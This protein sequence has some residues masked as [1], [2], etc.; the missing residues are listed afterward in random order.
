MAGSQ[1]APAAARGRLL[2]AP[3]L[4]LLAALLPTSGFGF[5][6]LPSRVV[7]FALVNR[8]HHHKIDQPIGTNQPVLTLT[9]NR[10]Q[11]P[12]KWDGQRRQQEWTA[13]AAAAAP[14]SSRPMMYVRMRVCRV[15][16]VCVLPDA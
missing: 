12:T 11:G 13:A 7:R 2:R 14:M 1:P 16:C 15:P 8:L 4:I 3:L 10:M 9:T 6:I 5:L